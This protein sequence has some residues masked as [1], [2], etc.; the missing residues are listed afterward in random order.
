MGQSGKDFP[1][2]EGLAFPTITETGNKEFTAP[3]AGR[4][5]QH[6]ASSSAHQTRTHE[7]LR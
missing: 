4:I 2:Q 7:K 5:Q 3:T 1:L 6:F